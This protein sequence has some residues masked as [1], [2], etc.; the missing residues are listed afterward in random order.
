M[1]PDMT[2]REFHYRWELNLKSRP[3][4]LWPYV[5]DTNR[6]NRDTWLPDVIAA[7]P[8][9]ANARRR[10]RFRRLPLRWE[11]E[12][13]EWTYPY[14]FGVVRRYQNGP[15]S[16]MRVLLE[17]ESQPEGG[18]RLVYQVWAQARNLLG[19]I[20][21]PL[22]IGQVSARRFKAAFTRYD[23]LALAKT[24][25]ITLSRSSHL[26]PGA[27]Q[28]LAAIRQRLIQAGTAADLVERLLELV[29][30]ADDLTLARIRP[31]LL[32]DLWGASRRDVLEIAL[33]ATRAGLLDFQWEILCPLCRGAEDRIYHHL[34]DVHSAA[35]CQ[36]C[37]IDFKVNF[38]HSVELTFRP[39]PA[40]R[41]VSG[42][43]FCVAGPRVTP[44]VVI[45]Q[46]IP[47]HEQRQVA[48]V[49]EAGRYRLRTMTLPGGQHLQVTAVGQS[50]ADLHAH[51]DGWPAHELELSPAPI[52]RLNNDTG[53]EQLLIL[54]RMVWSDQAA[55]AAEVTTLQ[56]FRDLF[57]NEALRPGEQ[58]SVGSLTVLF[59]DLRDSTQMYREI[60]DAP[61]FGVVMNHFDVLREAID[62]EGGALVKT[63]GD[64][65]MAVFQRPIAALQA[66]LRAHDVLATPPPGGRPLHLRAALHLGPSIAVSLN[67][68]LDYFGSTIN[69]AARLEKFSRGGD[70]VLSQ[71]VYDD[72]EIADFLAEPSHQLQI[73][74][75]SEM[76]K[77][78][79]EECFSLWRVRRTSG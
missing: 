34:N 14:R 8:V 7:A 77:G 43:D 52:L 70:V 35:H 20:G 27:Q 47:A 59:T 37:N 12:P 21:I 63:I 75:F 15:M 4:D 23:E 60:G 64:A 39:N 32:A 69:A 41:A 9:Q 65:V 5:A 66:I 44:H 54:E 76:L 33:L 2:N 25:P 72:P 40:I 48:P 50:Q 38:D 45:Q 58:I 31:Y 10:L 67:E 3:H 1:K 61:A 26:T 18:A 53:D 49:L 73:E 29:E 30:H 24:V 74:S 51:P 62:A 22:A 57:A 78:F 46:L 36:T 42:L 16:Q 28:R 56:R 68:R 19:V 71:A 79:D 13:F 11:E 55:T 6:F 17:M